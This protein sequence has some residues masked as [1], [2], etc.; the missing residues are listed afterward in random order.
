MI[1]IHAFIS[2]SL[3]TYTYIHGTYMHF[4][5]IHCSYI[6]PYIEIYKI[7]VVYIYYIHNCPYLLLHITDCPICDPVYCLLR[8]ILCIRHCIHVCIHM[9]KLLSDILCAFHGFGKSCKLPPPTL[10]LLAQRPNHPPLL[11][12]L[13]SSHTSPPPHT[14]P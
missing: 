4:L 3:N 2:T 1:C 11:P 13:S 10:A 14:L 6:P 5:H 7:C 8:P 12:N 9:I